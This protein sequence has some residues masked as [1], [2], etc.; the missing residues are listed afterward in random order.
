MRAIVY[1]AAGSAIRFNP[2]LKAEYAE[3][4]NKKGKIH[5]IARCAVARKL[6]QLAFAVV[7]KGKPF[8]VQY[9]LEAKARRLEAAR[10]L[11]G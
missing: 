3:I 4:Y 7:T 9:A 11:A 2:F 8:D 10:T 1:M 5:K 6:V